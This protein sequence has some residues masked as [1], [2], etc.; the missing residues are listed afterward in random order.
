MV[1]GWLG[2]SYVLIRHSTKKSRNENNPRKFKLTMRFKEP[3]IG[4]ASLANNNKQKIRKCGEEEELERVRV[5]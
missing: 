3:T 2:S 4:Q 1:D 5:R